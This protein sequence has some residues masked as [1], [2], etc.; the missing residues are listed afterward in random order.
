MRGRAVAATLRA[1]LGPGK[2][3]KTLGSIPPL[4]HPCWLVPLPLGWG[5]GVHG[6]GLPFCPPPPFCSKRVWEPVGTAP[7]GCAHAPGSAVQ[8]DGRRPVC[9]AS[10]TPSRS[11]EA[12]AWRSCVPAPILPHSLSDLSP[13]LLS[14]LPGAGIRGSTLSP[15][16]CSARVPLCLCCLPQPSLPGEVEASPQQETAAETSLCKAF[17]AWPCFA[18]AA[19]HPEASPAPASW[20]CL[21]CGP[22]PLP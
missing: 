12:W 6:F 5:R 18:G 9:N 21:P 7:Q 16:F 1:S 10:G 14:V 2:V 13:F 17:S 4:P 19:L 22:S 8:G 11:P 3:F 20:A 15:P